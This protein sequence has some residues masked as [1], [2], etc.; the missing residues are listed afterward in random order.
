[1]NQNLFAALGVVGLAACL[2]GPAR[3]QQTPEVKEKPPLYTFVSNSN[4]PRAHW[5]DMDK[6]MVDDA[7]LLD[8]ALANGTIAGFGA[9]HNMVHTPDGY[10]HDEWW[11]ANSMAGLLNVL[12]QMYKANATTS[13]G[14]LTATKHGDQILVSRFYN[15]KPGS[16]K[17][18]YTSGSIYKLKADAPDDA[19]GTISKTEIVPMLEKL[20]ADGAIV[21]YDIDTDAVHS[22]APGIFYVFAT[23]AN[24]EGL[25]RLRAARQE[26]IK[27]SPLFGPA[28]NSMTDYTAHRDMLA[29][30]NATFK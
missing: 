26:A 24:A 2:A 21:E 19:V 3:A 29:R 11:T 28:F 6:G 4:V 23:A 14:L 17:D 7:K 22:E 8:R 13:P 1:M 10:T 25:D 12:D 9:D 30:T 27:A 18:V 20:L 5:V 15:W 16:Y